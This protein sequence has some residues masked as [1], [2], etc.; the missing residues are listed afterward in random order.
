MGAPAAGRDASAYNTA[1]D[2]FRAAKRSLSEQLDARGKDPDRFP[3]APARMWT[4]ISDDRRDVDHALREILAPLLKRDPDP[5]SHQLCVGP[6]AASLS[7][8]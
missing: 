6:A 5:L 7:R 4:W 8:S 1:P 3:N 2:C